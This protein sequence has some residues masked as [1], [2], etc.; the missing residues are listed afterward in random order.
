MFFLDFKIGE[1]S[2]GFY[3]LDNARTIKVGGQEIINSDN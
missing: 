1:K 3:A 2:T